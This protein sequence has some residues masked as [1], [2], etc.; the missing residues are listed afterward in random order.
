MHS[1]RKRRKSRPTFL[2][3]G[4]SW[5]RMCSG[6][7]RR[8]GVEGLSRGRKV[9]R[10]EWELR[11]VGKATLGSWNKRWTER[12][13]AIESYLAWRCAMFCSDETRCE[14]ES[15]GGYSTSSSRGCAVD[16][17]GLQR[18]GVR[19]RPHH[20]ITTQLY[21]SLFEETRRLPMFGVP[22]NPQRCESRIPMALQTIGMARVN[23]LK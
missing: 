4:E 17:V 6:R 13:F 19:S 15:D 18:Q 10:G 20:T 5:D 9:A 16:W 1:L 11:R 7:G 12:K 8:G 14:G 23:K 22:N 3:S 21:G 2:P